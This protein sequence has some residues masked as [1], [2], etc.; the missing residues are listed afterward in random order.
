MYDPHQGG[1]LFGSASY[2]VE[3]LLYLLDNPT[4]EY[5][6]QTHLGS[7]KEIDDVKI[8][9]NFVKEVSVSSHLTTRVHTKNEAIFYFEKAMI[10][11]KNF[12]KS[13][14]L[15]IHMHEEDEIKTVS[16]DKVPEMVYEIEHIYDCIQKGLIQS[17]I[18]HEEITKTCVSLVDEI[19]QS[20]QNKNN[21]S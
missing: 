10:T 3:Y 19:Y 8:S 9:F 5:G 1:V 4:F 2:V 11:I 21:I 14:E 17:P 18:M 20:T 15:T 7:Q 13:N 6:A 12:W 16:Y